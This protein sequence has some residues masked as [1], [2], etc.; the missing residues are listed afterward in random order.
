MAVK[1]TDENG[2][3]EEKVAVTNKKGVAKVDVADEE[4]GNYT[5][6]CTFVLFC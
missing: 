5:V 6:E 2:T 4:P 3:T 1:E